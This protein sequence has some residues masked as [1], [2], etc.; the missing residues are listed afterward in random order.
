MVPGRVSRACLI[1]HRFNGTARD[2]R[3]Y[4][5]DASESGSAGM[6]GGAKNRSLYRRL[7]E[8]LDA[9]KTAV[10]VNGLS[11]NYETDGFAYRGGG[12]NATKAT[13]PGTQRPIS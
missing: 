2:V 12:R 3:G 5:F 8:V 13:A 11:G 9:T 7:R 1:P 10:V 6:S 4:W